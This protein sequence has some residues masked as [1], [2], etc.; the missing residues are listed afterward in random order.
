MAKIKTYLDSCVLIDA[1]KVKSLNHNKAL[2]VI[3]DRDRVF[4]WRYTLFRI[5]T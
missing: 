5:I 4:F 2:S 1:F 3:D